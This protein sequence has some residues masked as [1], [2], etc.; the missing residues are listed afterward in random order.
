MISQYSAPGSYHLMRNVSNQDAIS[1]YEN[2]EY[3]II[4]LA[5]GVS[6]CSRAQEGA[7]EACRAVT[8]LLNRNPEYFLQ[9]PAQFVANNVLD[10]ILAALKN[11]TVNDDLEPLS[12]TLSFVL[13]NKV[14]QKVL[15]FQLGDGLTVGRHDQRCRCLIQPDSRD[16]GTCATTTRGAAACCHILNLDCEQGDAFMLLTDG[17]W[18]MFVGHGR[19]RSSVVDAFVQG[20]YEYLSETLQHANPSD[21]NS[22]VIL[23]ID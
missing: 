20:D 21:D 17:A 19:L 6:S 5:D 1:T 4:A 7:Q 9:A 10:Y 18:K 14:N 16:G 13:L 11:L 22:Y 8:E 2:E 15:L 3:T 12:S 23:T